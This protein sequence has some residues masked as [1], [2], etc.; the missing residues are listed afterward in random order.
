VN[1]K[2]PFCGISSRD[3]RVL[4]PHTALGVN[5]TVADSAYMGRIW[6]PAPPNPVE[7]SASSGFLVGA[8]VLSSC[9]STALCIKICPDVS[10]LTARGN[11]LGLDMNCSQ[12]LETKGVMEMF[13]PLGMDQELWPL[14]SD[15]MV[16]SNSSAVQ[17]CMCSAGFTDAT[18][19][20]STL[21]LGKLVGLKNI[22]IGRITCKE[23]C[24]G[25]YQSI[26]KLLDTGACACWN[27]RGCVF[28][29]RTLL[30]TQASGNMQQA[31]LILP[32]T[33]VS[34]S[35]IVRC[36]QS[37][38]AQ[39]VSPQDIMVCAMQGIE[40]TFCNECPAECI[41]PHRSCSIHPTTRFCSVTCDHGYI[42]TVSELD[43]AYD[44]V[45][46]TVCPKHHY[47]ND[48]VDAYGNVLHESC[49]A[50]PLGQDNVNSY[51]R[52]P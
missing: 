32:D 51:H 19:G 14:C 13:M 30:Q 47:H 9:I 35:Y 45:L 46:K 26:A 44:C 41:K 1:N 11:S 50:C 20:D 18:Y 8:L 2:I 33:V 31:V 22:D 36:Q 42:R 43:A 5:A 48:S 7:M 39:R 17:Q 15:L 27:R 52:V 29:E 49:V 12:H 34:D 24:A 16:S 38:C 3:L 23:P 10:L 37:L 4:Y 25:P 6:Q 28:E 40:Y 21:G